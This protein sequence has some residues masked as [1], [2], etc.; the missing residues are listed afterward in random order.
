MHLV[1]THALGMYVC[2][3][4][5]TWYVR[6]HL[7]VQ[8]RPGLPE[9]LNILHAGSGPHHRSEKAQENFCLTLLCSSIYLLSVHTVFCECLLSVNICQ[10][11]KETHLKSE[12]V[13]FQLLSSIPGAQICRE[14]ELTDSHLSFDRRQF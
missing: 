5:C 7:V 13:N 11:V 12:K 9:F 4:V 8:L 10:P 3:Y 14:K 1:C 6:M 2:M